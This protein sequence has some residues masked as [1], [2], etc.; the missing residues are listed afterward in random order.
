MMNVE[1]SSLRPCAVYGGTDTFSQIRQLERGCDI[2]A[3]TPGR[4]M[5]FIDRCKIGLARVK[6]LIIDEA[7]R[8]LDMGFEAIVRAIVQK[9][10]M[11]PEHQTL[12][13]SAT[14]PRAI[15]ALARDFLRADYLF[16][17]VGRVGGTSTSITQRVISIVKGKC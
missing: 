6:Y 12:L 4:L 14:F 5:D 8:M 2:L 9:K 16:L 11:N 17:K 13:Y 7:D 10:G 15:R 3:A 1:K